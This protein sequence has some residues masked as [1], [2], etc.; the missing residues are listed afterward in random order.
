MDSELLAVYRNTQSKAREAAYRREFYR[1][2]MVDHRY[3]EQV[4]DFP[5]VS[6]QTNDAKGCMSPEEYVAYC[7][8][9]VNYHRL[10][11]SIY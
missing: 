1:M 2:P 6:C 11:G 4:C 5:I 10:Q 3:A 7:L 9:M 8:A